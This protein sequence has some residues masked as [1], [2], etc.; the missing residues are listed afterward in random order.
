MV[1]GNAV[2]V[3]VPGET[4]LLIIYTVISGTTA[5]P[6]RIKIDFDAVI[7]IAT[8]FGLAAAIPAVIA[9]NY[10]LGRIRVISSE[11]ENYS[12][13]FLNIIERHFE[14]IKSQQQ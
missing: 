1:T 9:Y 4:Q 12:S 11:M 7:L 3:A 10:Y 2:C 13:E 8:A 14:S 5:A 6:V